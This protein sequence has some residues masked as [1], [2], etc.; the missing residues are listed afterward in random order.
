LQ[1]K[2]VYYDIVDIVFPENSGVIAYLPPSLRMMEFRIQEVL[3][4]SGN[5]YPEEENLN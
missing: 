3:V 4:T 2:I 5:P 1:K